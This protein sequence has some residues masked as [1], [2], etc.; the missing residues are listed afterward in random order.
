MRFPSQY[1]HPPCR[2]DP[3]GESAVVELSPFSGAFL[4]ILPSISSSAPLLSLYLPIELPPYRTGF[5]WYHLV[6][7]RCPNRPLSAIM[8]STNSKEPGMEMQ[9]VDAEQGTKNPEMAETH[10]SGKSM[11]T[12]YDQRDMRVMGKLQ[13]LRVRDVYN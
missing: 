7:T 10:V 8:S 13:E 6:Y 3:S 12:A 1:H 9:A 11:G 5:S 2:A 4:G